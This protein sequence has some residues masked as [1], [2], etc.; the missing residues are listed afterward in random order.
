MAYTFLDATLLTY[1]IANNFLGEGLFS[2]NSKKNISI[3]GILDNRSTNL[4][5]DGVKE[6]IDKIKIITDN[7]FGVYDDIVINGINLGKGTIINVSFPKNNPIRIG[8]YIYTIEVT[9]NANFANAPI[10]AVYG[11]YIT[12]VTGVISNFDENFRFQYENDGRYNYNH[13]INLRYFDDNS[14]IITK[15]KNL[16]ENLFNDN[17]SL[18]L[19]GSYSGIYKDLRNKKN[20][21][22]ESYNL[23]D[24]SCSFSKNI[25]I[26]TKSNDNYTNKVSHN[27]TFDTNGKITVQEN[28]L[29]TALD[30]TLNFTAEN[31]FDEAIANSYSRCQNIL[32]T[33]SQKYNLATSD[34]LYAQPFDIGKTINIL[35][36]SLSYRISYINDIAFEGN[37]IN[38]YNINLSQDNRGSQVYTENGEITKVG[39][40][41]TISSL[42]EVKG[43]YQE[44]QNRASLAYPT[45][46]YINNSLNFNVM[47]TYNNYDNVFNYS[48][49]KTNDNS[50]LDNDP[51]YKSLDVKI[52]DQSPFGT[53]KEYIIPNKIPKNILFLYGNNVEIGERNIIIN[54]VLNRP[55]LNI[56]NTPTSF[57]LQNLKSL[58]I[59]KG[60]DLVSTESFIDNINYSYGSD[61]NFSFNVNIKYLKASGGL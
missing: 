55:N 24:K 32:T 11:N 39:Q 40:L 30:N 16:A 28:G 21:F 2:L 41:G 38:K 1:E 53:T 35:D 50:V 6:S 12:G 49:E 13:E 48:I 44:A 15:S 20:Y 19:I 46:K 34:N 56:W 3:R 58:A 52:E 23:I 33:Y 27:L 36:N 4:D 59:Q 45:F 60:L 42:D 10:G 8:E 7:T 54:G 25:I 22:S 26:D 43:K 47:N 61:Y 14:D 18:G 31:Y 29:I 51:Y 57:P 37:L 17:V 5:S 9:S